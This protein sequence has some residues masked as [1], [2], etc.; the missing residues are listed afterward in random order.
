MQALTSGFQ[1]HVPK[2]IEAGEL[3][4]VIASLAGRLSKDVSG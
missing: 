1:A 2:P 4:V 3:V